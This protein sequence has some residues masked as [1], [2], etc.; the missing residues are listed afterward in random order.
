MG[1]RR[2]AV[3]NDPSP[4]NFLFAWKEVGW[5]AQGR[6]WRK[7]LA[8][9]GAHSQAIGIGRCGRAGMIDR[10]L[11][12]GGIVQALGILAEAAAIEPVIEQHALYVRARLRHRNAFHEQ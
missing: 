6:P 8:N 9:V 7:L 12:A 5:P 2:Y 11:T 4:S 10:P 3:A 1:G